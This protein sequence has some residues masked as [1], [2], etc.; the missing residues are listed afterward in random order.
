LIRGVCRELKT[1]TIFDKHQTM[2]PSFQNLF[3]DLEDQ[4]VKILESVRQLTPEQL[5]RSVSPGKWSVAQILS[6]I[7]TAERMSLKYVEKKMQGIHDVA[8]SGWWEELKLFAL[9][10]S[11][12]LPGI[13]FK[14]PKRVLENTSFYGDHDTIHKEWDRVR[15]DFKMLLSNITSEQAKKLV[16]R[17]PIAGYLNVRQ[18]LVFFREHIIHHTPQIKKLINLK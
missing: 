12:R 10:V 3:E 4:R 6:H 2:N 14:A 1:L 17:H 13:K 16:Y 15:S 11:Q 8:D 18:C 7:I 5:N 9:K